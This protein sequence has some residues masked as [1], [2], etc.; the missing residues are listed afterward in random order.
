VAKTFSSLN[1]QTITTPTAPSVL[2]P[3]P[4]PSTYAV[5]AGGCASNNPDPTGNGSNPTAIGN[6]VVPAGGTGVQAPAFITL[7]A[8]HLTVRTGSAPGTLTQGSVVNSADV[9]VTDMNCTP[10]SPKTRI[11]A[12]NASG[13]LADSATGPTDPGLPYSTNY[14]ICADANIG[15]ASPFKMNYVRTTAIGTPIEQVPVTD[16]TAGTVK[17]IYL[18][19]PGAV[20]STT[21]A[22]AQCSP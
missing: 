4:S 3:F 14:K 7:P 15:G 12:T 17:T 5:Y 2:F 1:S 20:S 6:V 9:H 16:P 22:G 11:L 8:L 21:S 19:G 18:T 13:Q 10:T